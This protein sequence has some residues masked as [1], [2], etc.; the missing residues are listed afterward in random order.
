M[1]LGILIYDIQL[2]CKLTYIHYAEK[3][4]KILYCIVKNFGSKKVWQIRIVGSLVEKTW[5]IEVH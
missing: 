4:T 1:M 5:R 2:F 3:V